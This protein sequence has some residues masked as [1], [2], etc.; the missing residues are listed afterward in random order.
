MHAASKEGLGAAL[1]QKHDN[2]WK[3]V[4]KASRFLNS[5][6]NRTVTKN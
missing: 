2:I 1:A 3:T 4:A 5:L 6:M